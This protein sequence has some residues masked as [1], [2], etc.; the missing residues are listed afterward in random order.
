MTHTEYSPYVT[1]S[2]REV[3][4][5]KSKKYTLNKKDMKDVGVMVGFTAVGTALLFFVEQVLP[6]IDFGEYNKYILPMI[7]V[8]TYSVRKFVQG[9]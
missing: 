8:I 3:T 6:F 1:V 5:M 7:P 2:T 9:K 4:N